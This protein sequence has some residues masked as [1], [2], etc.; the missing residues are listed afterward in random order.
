VETDTKDINGC[1]TKV[2]VLDTLQSFRVN[3][4][5][6]GKED[7]ESNSLLPPQRDN[8]VWEMTRLGKRKRDHLVI[9]ERKKHTM[10]N[11]PW[12]KK[13]YKYNNNNV[14]NCEN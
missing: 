1:K 8:R 11:I 10:V 6:N 3:M 5:I 12:K 2:R 9:R 4:L 7:N 14:K 13:Y